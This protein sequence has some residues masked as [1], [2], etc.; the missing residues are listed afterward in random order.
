[1]AYIKN[2]RTIKLLIQTSVSNNFNSRVIYNDK[3]IKIRQNEKCDYCVVANDIRHINECIYYI[4]ERKKIL[5][6]STLIF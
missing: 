3:I 5:W 6:M 2:L 1:M 4:P